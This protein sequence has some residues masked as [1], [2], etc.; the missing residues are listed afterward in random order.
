M[1]ELGREVLVNEEDV[2][3]AQRQAI[4]LLGLGV[5]PTRMVSYC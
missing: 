1:A 4:Y 3:D 5:F 2:H